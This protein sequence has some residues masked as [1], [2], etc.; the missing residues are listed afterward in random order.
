[1]KII[2]K[3][4]PLLLVVSALI[5]VITY[6]ISYL[7]WSFDG[8]P[9][10][11]DTS[12]HMARALLMNKKGPWP[13]FVD[14]DFINMFYHL[15]MS[16]IAFYGLNVLYVYESTIPLFL[17]VV[18]L[19]LISRFPVIQNNTAKS[20]TVISFSSWPIIYRFI[21][22]LHPALLG[23]IFS[24]AAVNILL[25][26]PLYVKCNR[27]DTIK[28]F[29]LILLASLTHIETANYFILSAV[30]ASFIKIFTDI[31]HRKNISL[32][33]KKTYILLPLIIIDFLYLNH[34]NKLV[35]LSSTG[36]I[37]ENPILKIWGVV[38]G[39][40][41][42]LSCLRLILKKPRSTCSISHYFFICMSTIVF[43]SFIL[44]PLYVRIYPYFERALAVFPYPLIV[45]ILSEALLARIRKTGTRLI[46]VILLLI[47][48][49]S[50]SIIVAHDSG[51]HLR[52]WITKEGY[53]AL[54]TTR[55][56]CESDNTVIFVFYDLDQ[57][58]GGLAYLYDS[59][60][61]LICG[62]HY[63]YLGTVENL[64]NGSLTIFSNV[65]SREASIKF[66]NR[67]INDNVLKKIQECDKNTFIIIIKDFYKAEIPQ[68]FEKI[69]PQVY[70]A[71]SFLLRCNI[72]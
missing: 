9:L 1:M 64:L 39:G 47:S 63:S 11:W 70:I 30:L 52:T 57:Y 25:D 38:F 37:Q 13:I 10:G 68:T 14:E 21:A 71:R 35:S 40:A 15:I 72:I 20:L 43:I 42:F 12:T 34:L 36:H 46:A 45:G 58:A 27:I 50:L 23:T 55:P 54:F 60:S 19:Y 44:T 2:K 61:T 8:I 62:E 32:F 22:D 67:M 66:Y 18:L 31:N 48:L 51:S 7:T 59:W 28:L 56:Y 24:L 16:P 6:F 5:V 3:L 17:T 65:F 4:Y 69:S 41:Y 26:K 49:I 29:I 53:S 33:V